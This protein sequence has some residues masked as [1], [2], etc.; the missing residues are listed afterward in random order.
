MAVK[1]HRT[2]NKKP[3]GRGQSGQPRS[4]PRGRGGWG[5][6]G[7]GQQ[8]LA[9]E[10]SSPLRVG[11]VRWRLRRDGSDLGPVG[12]RSGVLGLLPRVHVPSAALPRD[13]QEPSSDLEKRLRFSRRLRLYASK[14]LT[15]LHVPVHQSSRKWLIFAVGRELYQFQVLP[16]GLST[17]PRTFTRVVKAWQSI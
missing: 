14:V 4:R 13:S 17:A 16:S 9:T 5:G 10:H 7:G 3:Q 11:D 6:R 1:R 2:N 12:P 15:Y 8:R